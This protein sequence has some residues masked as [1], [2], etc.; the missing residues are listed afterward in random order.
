MPELELRVLDELDEG[1][2]K[3]P[4]MRSV[5]NEPL[6]QHTCDLLLDRFRVRLGKQVEQRAAEIVRVAVGIAQL[7]GYG[8]QKQIPTCIH[9][10]THTSTSRVSWLVTDFF[11]TEPLRINCRH[12]FLQVGCRSCHSKNRVKAMKRT[13][14]SEARTL[15]N[16]NHLPVSFF[17]DP[18]TDS[19]RR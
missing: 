9:T 10:H 1:D 16:E 14:G 2:E 13:Q 6:Q 8:V 17:I 11:D 5:D 18:S 15:T 4:R 12:R 19:F 7:I 3:T